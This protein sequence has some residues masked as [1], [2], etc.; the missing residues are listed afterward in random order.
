[1]PAQSRPRRSLNGFLKVVHGIGFRGLAKACSIG[2]ATLGIISAFAP[3]TALAGPPFF[4]DDPE[5]APYRHWEGYIASQYRRD[6]DG[7]AFTV[8]QFEVNYGVYPNL[9]LH[10]IAPFLR[11]KPE[12][13]PSRHGYGDTELGLKFRFIQE[14]G[15]RPMVGTFPLVELPTGDKDKGLGNGKAQVFLPVWLQKSRGP[16][17]SYGGGGYEINPGPG[18]KDFWVVGA[19]AQRE[20]FQGWILG[21]EAFHKTADQ[22]GGES[23]TGFNIGAMVNFSETHHLLLSTGRDLQGPNRFSSYIA[24]QITFGP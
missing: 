13:E 2:M 8:P 5:P 9:M 22:E 18:N 1:M 4:T 6:R 16:W 24:Y 23:S 12:G 15:L 14:S 21:A 11:V 19:Q 20:I 3:G 10:L 7:L 17:T